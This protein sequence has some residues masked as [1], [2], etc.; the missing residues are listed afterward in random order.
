MNIHA[1]H[2]P[3]L[4]GAERVCVFRSANRVSH[5]A[6]G[7]RGTPALSALPLLD[8]GI[9]GVNGMGTELIGRSIS[10]RTD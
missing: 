1:L 4:R 7:R 9:Y 10:D 5:S 2:S 8:M 3:T 6:L